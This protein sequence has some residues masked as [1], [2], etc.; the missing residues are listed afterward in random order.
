MHVFDFNDSTI[1]QN[2]DY[3]S[4]SPAL[5]LNMFERKILDYNKCEIDWFIHYNNKKEISFI[6]FKLSRKK[7]EYE[8]ALYPPI[9]SGEPALTYDQWISGENKEPIKKEIHLIENKNASK[10]DNADNNENKNEGGKREEVKDNEL[11]EKNKIIEEK[12]NKKQA[13]YDELL[14]EKEELNKKLKELREKKVEVNDRLYV[15]LQE[16]AKKDKEK[17]E[18]VENEQNNKKNYKNK[19]GW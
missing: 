9:S 10:S 14:K 18:K 4:N 2:N 7:P 1:Y 17:E 8:P 6:S 15:A 3:K 19:R 5:S 12:V 16:K 11:E 13:I